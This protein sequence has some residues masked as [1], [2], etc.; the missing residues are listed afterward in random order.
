MMRSALWKLVGILATLTA[1]ARAT[2]PVAA[3]GNW[4]AFRGP[5]SRGIADDHP[6]LP[7]RWSDKENVLWKVELDGRGWSSP[8]VW[9]RRVVVTSAITGTPLE[10]PRK[11]LYFGGNR[12]EPPETEVRWVVTCL[13]VDTGLTLWETQVASGPPP[14]PVHLKNSFASETPTTDGERIYAAFGNVGIFCLNMQGQRVWEHRRLPRPMRS[15]WGPAASPVLHRGRLYVVNDNEQD[16]HLAALDAATGAELWRVPREEK[17]NWSTPFIWKN[18][19]R[20][21]LVVPGSGRTR[22]YDLDGRLLYEFGGGSDITIATP[23][24]AHGLL[25]VS[26]GYLLDRSRPIWAVRPG[27][28]GDV[29]LADGETANQAIAWRRDDAAPYNPTTLVY[30]DELHVIADRGLAACYDAHTGRQ[31]YRKQRLPEGRA[32]TASPWAYNGL[33]FCVNE[34]GETFVLRAG[35]RFELL[36]RNLLAEDDMVMATPA[37]A[38]DRL[39]IRTDR[40][41]YCL[42]DL[43]AEPAE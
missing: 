30:G 20:T 2:T 28:S 18:G 39:L 11:G 14:G 1:S 15:G 35:P 40:R 32:F 8:I 26:S 19:L 4:P 22:C 13:D 9:G 41:L 25:F 10:D 29:T 5:E 34:Y 37:I 33:V 16:S 36:Q 43:G 7:S 38:G 42:Q 17:S 24:A 27:G 3:D 21:E 23:Y 31:H 6:R 12:E